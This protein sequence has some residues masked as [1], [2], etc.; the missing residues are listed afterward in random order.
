MGLPLVVMDGSR[1]YMG[2]TARV[3]GV[4]EIKV[5]VRRRDYAEM[6]NVA[7]RRRRTV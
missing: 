1:Y 4:G 7:E 2:G 5:A 6:M 3:S